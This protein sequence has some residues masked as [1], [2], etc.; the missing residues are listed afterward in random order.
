MIF[1]KIN[2]QDVSVKMIIG[3]LLK[4]SLMNQIVNQLELVSNLRYCQRVFKM[5]WKKMIIDKLNF[6]FRMII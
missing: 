6:Q 3:I 1:L 4:I 2:F 5:D